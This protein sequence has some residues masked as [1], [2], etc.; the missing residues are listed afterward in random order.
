MK[1]QVMKHP[2][3]PITL[4]LVSGIFL[5]DY[6]NLVSGTFY[7]TIVLLLLLISGSFLAW[8]M[9]RNTGFLNNHLFWVFCFFFFFMLGF[10]I[11]QNHLSPADKE[12]VS[13][14]FGKIRIDEV[15]KPNAFGKRYYATFFS[16]ERKQKVILYQKT[17]QKGF[18]VGNQFEG[19]F[20]LEMIVLPKNPYQF[21]YKEYLARKNI[22]YQ[23]QAPERV[24]LVEDDRNFF[25]Y[26]DSWR[27]TIL[28]SYKPFYF[29]DD[30]YGVISTLLLGRRNELSPEI[31]RSYRM[32]GVAHVL[33]I[34]GLHVGIVYAVIRLVLGKII[35]HKKTVLFIT[36]GLLVLFAVLS[37]LSGSVI[38]AVVMFSIVGIGG[39]A[40][41][42][43]QTIHLLA[44]SMFCILIV[45]PLYL[46]DIGFQLSY[47]AVFSIVW[48]YPPLQAVILKQPVIVRPVLSL[49]GVSFVAQL[50]V[51]P[52][53]LFYFGQ[54][55]WL[56]LA[57]NMIA[58]PTITV[59][60]TL[61][62][63]MLPFN[64]LVPGISLF[65]AKIIS[66]LLNSCNQII[67]KLATIDGSVRYDIKFDVIECLLT[68]FLLIVV[69][70]IIR[71]YRFFKVVVLLLLLIGVQVTIVTDIV[72][73]RLKH[74]LLVFYDYNNVS[75]VHNKSGQLNVFTTDT[76]K[77]SSMYLSAYQ[78]KNRHRGEDFQK[79]ENILFLPVVV[80]I[81]DSTGIYTKNYP[82][83]IAVLWHNPVLDFEVFLEEVNPKMV[84]FHPNNPKWRVN[85]W[86]SICIERKI[87]FHNMK[88]KGF[89][90]L[91]L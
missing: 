3:I 18:R 45:Q 68:F 17:E 56:F 23:I 80:S 19:V 36:I 7:F 54:M 46:F 55:P 65:L 43:T 76:L 90:R 2:M 20:R 77:R 34:S 6:F 28:E 37:G 52:V 13:F 32:T 16:E 67:Q 50:G 66:F 85:Y 1:I 82:I 75:I 79:L 84:V 89:Y 60:L 71:N 57:G 41:Y 91:S 70:S 9:K 73:I 59:V 44:I 69:G 74:E 30:V 10:F 31:E 83:D 88:E 33:A 48:L 11:H 24:L 26:V 39:L 5:S 64:F 8:R 21:T 87:P 49:L 38:R 25:Y 51:L 29:S 58:V 81:I 86:E 61:L 4:F 42:K 63:I 27:T 40:H 53:T 22:F 78:K 12:K 15:L 72:N 14:Q 62:L 35:R 47:M